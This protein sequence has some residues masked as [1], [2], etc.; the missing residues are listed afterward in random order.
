[1]VVLFSDGIRSKLD[2]AGELDLLR[3]HPAV[4]AQRVVE[5]FARD[6]DDVLVMVVG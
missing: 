2:L 6:D 1:M 3:E 4:I 5:R